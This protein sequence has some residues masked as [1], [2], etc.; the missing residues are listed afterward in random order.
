LIAVSGFEREH[1]GQEYP[2]RLADRDSRWPGF[3][4]HIVQ[5]GN[6]R[7]PCLSGK[8]DCRDYLQALDAFPAWIEAM[9]SR[10]T[11]RGQPGPRSPHASTTPPEKLRL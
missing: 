6:D 11:R 3:P 1:G 9:T 2:P 5:R 10:A 4:P 7:Q 8:A